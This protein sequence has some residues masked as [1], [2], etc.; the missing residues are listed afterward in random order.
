MEEIGTFENLNE[1]VMDEIIGH[2]RNADVL[3]LNNAYPGLK[4][5]VEL[6]RKRVQECKIEY[7]LACAIKYLN[8]TD[9]LYLDEAY[10]EIKENYPAVKEKVIQSVEKISWVFWSNEIAIREVEYEARDN[11]PNCAEIAKV[12]PFCAQVRLCEICP[13]YVEDRRNLFRMKNKLY[14]PK[15]K[16]F[17]YDKWQLRLHEDRRKLSEKRKKKC[18]VSCPLGFPTLSRKRVWGE[19]EDVS[20]I[21]WDSC[22]WFKK[23]KLT[24]W[25]ESET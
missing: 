5:C 1:D 21:D 23:S 14:C 24:T 8:D 22:F 6:M 12:D 3:N 16:W 4:N 19:L 18:W 20:T 25:L 9:L 7:G 2:L 13:K 15:C 17:C 10:P 11:C